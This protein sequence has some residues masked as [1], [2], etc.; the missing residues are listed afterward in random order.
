MLSKAKHPFD[1]SSAIYAQGIPHFV[2]NDKFPA[3]VG[4]ACLFC[5]TVFQ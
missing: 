2:R 1:E 3:E 5:F 4:R